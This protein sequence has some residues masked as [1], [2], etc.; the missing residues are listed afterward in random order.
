MVLF[1][2]LPPRLYEIINCAI[3]STSL[4]ALIICVRYLVSEYLWFKHK[5][6]MTSRDALAEVIQYRVAIGF[7]VLMSGEFP[8]MTWV[9]LARY[10]MNT[11]QDAVWMG[12]FPWVMLPVVASMVSI[13]GMACILRGLT[14]RVWGRWGYCG[15]LLAPVIPIALTQFF[16]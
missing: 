4:M 12:T 3:A 9:W 2:A 8:R 11:D 1:E 16:R 10:L 6:Q 14:P 5:V 7:T 15:C 13:I